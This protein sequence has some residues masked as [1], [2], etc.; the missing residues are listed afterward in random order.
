MTPQGELKLRKTLAHICLISIV[1]LVLIPFVMV[2][3]ASL[4]R[5]QFPPSAL[6][7][8]P[9]QLSLEHWEFVLGI[10]YRELVNAATGE[11]RMI[12]ASPSPLLW[13]WNSVLVSGCSSLGIILLSG[14][15]AY[16]FPRMRFKFRGSILRAL[17]ILQMFPA[18]RLLCATRLYG[19]TFSIDWP[20]HTSR[21]N[22]Y[23]SG[24]DLG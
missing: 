18:V 15:A 12:Q 16:A 20:E 21:L 1:T 3:I 11:T 17:L 4:R 8:K 22:R 7:V 23:L 9:D 2:I 13:L 5:G 24:R 14:T 6:L 19:P 10:P